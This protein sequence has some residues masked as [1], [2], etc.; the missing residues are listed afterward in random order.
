MSGWEGDIKEHTSG[1]A[2]KSIGV[3]KFKVGKTKL[4]EWWDVE[5]AKAIG[6]RKR[7]NRKQRNL[8]RL[9]KRYRGNY[10][11][12]WAEAWGRYKE[13]KKAAQKIIENWEEKQARSL[14]N[15]PRKERRNLGGAGP[16]QGVKL[17]VD[18]REASSKKEV[19]P[20][21]EDSWCR[22]IWKEEEEREEEDIGNVFMGSQFREMGSVEIEEQDIKLA[23]RAI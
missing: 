6:D 12:E 5:V 9:A 8:A 21:V 3:K 23:V 14:N 11:I 2:K 19:V 10:E 20:V 18:G 4:K 16:H 7:G 15:M 17:K 1:Q 22:S 13:A